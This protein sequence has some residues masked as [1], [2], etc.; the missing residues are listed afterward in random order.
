MAE[1]KKAVFFGALLMRLGTR[2]YERFV[3][4]LEF[5]VRYT[6]AEANAAVS[7]VNYGMDAYVVSR[8]PDTEIG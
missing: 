1:G 2:R 7:L 3:Q 8:V 5:E 4:A 6:G